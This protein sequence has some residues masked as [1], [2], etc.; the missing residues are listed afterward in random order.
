MPEKGVPPTQ[1]YA[2]GGLQDLR[3]AR[4]KG[5]GK[6]QATLDAL[7]EATGIAI[8]NLPA[9]KLYKIRVDFRMDN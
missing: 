5:R 6:S 2:Q 7:T 9:T 1:R 8:L 3:K 4:V